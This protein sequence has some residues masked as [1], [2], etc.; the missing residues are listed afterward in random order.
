MNGRKLMRIIKRDEI[1]I[2]ITSFKRDKK[3]KKII[4]TINNELPKNIKTEII[5]SGGNKKFNTNILPNKK[6]NLVIRYIKNKINSN[7]IKRNSGFAAAKN[8][9]IVF[10]DDDCLPQKNFIVEYLELFKIIGKK[11]I[12]CGSVIYE[13]DL[14]NKS[15]FIKYRNSRHFVINKSSF[16]LTV[17]LNPSKIVTMNMGMKKTKLSKRLKLFDERFGSYGFEDFE[18]GYRFIKNGFRIIPCYPKVL[19]MDE[20]N[21]KEYLNKIEYTSR[22]SINLLKKIN[23]FAWK[24]IFYSK[25]EKNFW[26]QNLFKYKLL[27]IFGILIQ[28][29]IIIIEKI[30]FIYIP[31]LIRI[32]I[33][34]SYCKGYYDRKINKSNNYIWYK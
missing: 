21:F 1:S 18:F 13:D 4:E 14:I 15:N 33:F 2:I 12:L 25:I 26:F 32:A 10:L 5:I 20:R 7:A 6:P 27:I 30:P 34:L 29:M 16:K 9:N 8:E 28:N 17:K 3:L 22:F 11:D 24:S 23:K 31:S 19:H